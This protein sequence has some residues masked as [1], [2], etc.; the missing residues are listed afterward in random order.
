MLLMSNNTGFSRS[1]EGVQE[2]PP[3]TINPRMW[4]DM[5]TNEWTKFKESIT[6]SPPPCNE[7]SDEANKAPLEGPI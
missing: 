7:I 4:A 1:L 6:Q 3:G 2:W 5:A